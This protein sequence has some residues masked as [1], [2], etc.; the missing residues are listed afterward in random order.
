MPRVISTLEALGIARST[1]DFF[2]ASEPRF[3]EDVAEGAAFVVI[4]IQ[5]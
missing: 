1:I 4:L 5:S 2:P 3:G